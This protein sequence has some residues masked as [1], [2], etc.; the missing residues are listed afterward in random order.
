MVAGAFAPL[1]GGLI[2]GQDDRWLLLGLSAAAMIAL[3]TPLMTYSVRTAS[4][5]KRQ[6]RSLAVD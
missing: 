6:A 1:V 4:E 5:R 3:C 2:A